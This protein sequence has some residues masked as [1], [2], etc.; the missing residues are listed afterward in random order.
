[1]QGK[2]KRALD[3]ILSVAAMVTLCPLFTLVA[4]SIRIKM[5]CPLLFSHIRP[6]YR[7]QPFTV[8]KF[9]SMTDAC[10]IEGNLLADSDRLTPLGRFLRRWS[11][12]ELPQLWNVVRGDMSL[13]GPRPLLMEYL[14]K[15]T[16]EQARRHEVRPGVTGW[17]QVH[18]R[19]N[20]VFSE[21]LQMDVWYIDHWSLLL[22]LKVILLTLLR[23][24][25]LTAVGASPEVEKTDDLGFA[26]L[27]Q[28]RKKE[29]VPIS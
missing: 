20:L 14:E 25:T 9:R 5:G 10:D 17:A 29:N 18:G 22:D 21:R 3:I 19:Q 4:L 15:Y 6:G 16:P 8:F 2:L 12:D 13:V 23:L 11:L 26:A 24:P 1:M 27:I 28:K 7:A